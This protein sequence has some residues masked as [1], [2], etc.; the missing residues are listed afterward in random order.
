MEFGI[1]VNGYIPGPAAHDSQCEHDELVEQA[2]YVV[3]ADKHNWKYAWFGEHHGL[4]EYSHMSAPEVVMGWVAAQTDYIHL[5]SGITSLPTAKEHPA[6]IAERAAMLDHMTNRRFEFGTGRGAGSHELKTFNVMDPSV[7]KSMW[8]EVIREIP[9]MW[10]QKDY[11]FHGQHFTVP[12]PHN[13]LPKPYGQGHPPIW[14]ACGNPETFKKAGDHGIGAIAFNFEPIYN[15]QGRI[16]AYKEAIQAPTNQIGQFR[17]DNIMMTNTVVCLS[18]REDAREVA[19]RRGFGYLVTMVNMYHDTMQAPPDAIVW[20]NPPAP[21][22]FQMDDDMLDMLIGAG[23]LMCGTPEDVS[24]Q[25]TQ[26][27]KVGCDQ[28]VFGLPIEQ[29][30]PEEVY[31]ML[32]VFGD[33][34]IP[35]HDLDRTHSTDRYRATAQPKFPMFQY[36]VPEFNIPVLPPN[37]RIPA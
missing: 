24:E 28:L 35:E 3:F 16:D 5:A 4:T 25:L 13:I 12:T 2:K 15:L 7:T 27:S 11:D 20:P 32:E 14:V 9:R 18:N 1:F 6:R 22:E 21:P 36:P 10:E 31:E 23:L 19:K 33:K 26:Y 8:D 17:N 30:H 29:M 34:V 37:A